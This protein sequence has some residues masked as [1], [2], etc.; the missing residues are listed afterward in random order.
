[1]K[2]QK[3]TKYRQRWPAKLKRE[4]ARRYEAGEF[5]LSVAAE[6][7]GLKHRNS[8]WEMVKWYRKEL[9]YLSA[10]ELPMPDDKRKGAEAAEDDIDQMT[11]EELRKNLRT[12]RMET[13]AWKTV[14]LQAEELLDISIIKKSGAKQSGKCD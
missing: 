6:I 1:M 3:E 12:S 5:S 9:Q 2:V 8:A 4:L 11:V 10:K 14:V 13:E 7:Y